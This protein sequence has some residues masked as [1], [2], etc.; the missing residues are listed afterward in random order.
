MTQLELESWQTGTATRDGPAGL[1]GLVGGLFIFPATGQSQG[2]AVQS[3]DQKLESLDHH[4]PLHVPFR[5]LPNF[6]NEYKVKITRK[7]VLTQ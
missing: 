1:G 2:R 4:T 5:A 6:H 7:P 3:E